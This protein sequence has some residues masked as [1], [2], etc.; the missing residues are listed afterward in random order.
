MR[1]LDPEPHDHGNSVT[2]NIRDNLFLLFD[3][4]LESA[5]RVFENMRRNLDHYGYSLGLADAEF[6]R[7]HGQISDAKKRV[8]ALRALFD[9]VR[10]TG[11]AHPRRQ[12]CR[13]ENPHADA[14]PEL[15]SIDLT[16]IDPDGIIVHEIRGSS[17]GDNLTTGEVIGCR[18]IHDASIV[19]A[20]VV[21][22][23]TKRN[24]VWLRIVSG[25]LRTT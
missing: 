25:T 10:R 5:E 8:K 12:H 20:R 17:A 23:T 2:G 9:D 7:T 19:F 4:E 15:L 18:S 6:S 1:Y 11:R 16:N 13:P 3:L 21:G 24:Y 22:F 14:R